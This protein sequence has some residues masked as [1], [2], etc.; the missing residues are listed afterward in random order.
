ML[1]LFRTLFLTPRLVRCIDCVVTTSSRMSMQHCILVA[2]A[3]TG[4]FQGGSHVTAFRMAS[5]RISWN[6]SQLSHVTDL[7]GRHRLHRSSSSRS[8]H[9][10]TFRRSLFIGPIPWGHSGPLSR[11]V[12]VVDIDAHAARDSTASDIC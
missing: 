4:K 12:V 2:S 10:P 5:L 3:R 6:Q 11:V 7:P 8:L 1:E 9:V